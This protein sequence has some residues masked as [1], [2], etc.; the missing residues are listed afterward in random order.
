M[1]K[2][3]C[4]CKY[5]KVSIATS[6]RPYSNRDPWTRTCRS[7]TTSALHFHFL[8]ESF[9]TLTVESFAKSE[10][11]QRSVIL[12]YNITVVFSHEICRNTPISQLASSP[13]SKD[14][15]LPYFDRFSNSL[16]PSAVRFSPSHQ[17]RTSS[18]SAQRF[19][20][21]THSTIS[22]FVFI[23][24]GNTLIQSNVQYCA[25]I[26]FHHY[27]CPLDVKPMTLALLATPLTSWDPGT[28]SGP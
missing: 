15:S 2:C 28:H 11:K 25:N 6:I 3:K 7:A 27:A 22:T 26:H 16:L 5:V 24:I 21:S 13:S 17:P 23:Q 8:S 12:Y 10:L 4:K 18:P 9:P 20:L 14:L 19:V 1:T